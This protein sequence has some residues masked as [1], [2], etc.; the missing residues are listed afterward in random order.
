M[1][2]TCGSSSPSSPPISVNPRR[3]RRSLAL[4]PLDIRAFLS[5][6]R[7]EAVQSR[8]LFVSLR[9]LRSFARHLEREGH[10][11]ASAFAA[12]RTPKMEKNLP[13]PLSAASAVAVT[14]T[15]LARGRRPEALDP[16]A[17]RRRA[18]ASLRRRAAHLR[19]ARPSTARRADQWHRFADRHRQGQQD[20]QRPSHPADPACDRRIPSALPLCGPA[21]RPA[22]RRRARRSAVAADHSA[23]GRRN[24][25]HARACPT[26][27]RPH[28]LRHSFATH[29]LARGGDLR[30]IQEL[31][32]HA[33]LSTTQLYTKIDAARLM[34]AFD[35][36]HPRSR[37]RRRAARECILVAK[38]V[39]ITPSRRLTIEQPPRRRA[40]VARGPMAATDRDVAPLAAD[41]HHFARAHG[42][43]AAIDI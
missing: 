1:G 5:A 10:G 29:L 16:G 20:A 38:S 25:R 27:R 21:G 31:L 3:S 35:A 24:A 9:S 41:L 22:F 4:K 13:R 40:D 23:R 28:A 14:E 26:A 12:I 34:D 15:E 17:R 30:G 11:T 8:S 18:V 2:A 36:A 39:A 42:L 32:G 19:G 43:A 33:S 6:R 7:R 37:R